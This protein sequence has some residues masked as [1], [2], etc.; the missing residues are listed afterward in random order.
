MKLISARYLAFAV[1]TY[2]I[3]ASCKNENKSKLFSLMSPDQTG[4]RFTNTLLSTEEFNI[5]SYRNFYNGAGVAISDFNN[6]DLPEIYLISNM[7]TNKL[8]QNKGN[9]TF[10]DITASAGVGG[11]K[12][13]S[14]GVVVADVNG[15][16]YLD[17]Y[18]CNAGYLPDKSDQENELFINNGDLTFTEM[19]AEYGLNDNGFTTHAAFFDYDLDGDLDVYVLNNSF[20]PVN[21]LNYSN[22][23]EL[24]SKDWPVRDFLKGGGDK[25][26]RNDNGRFTD[27]TREA[28]IYSSLIGFGL[29]VTV[30]D[31]NGD[32]LPDIYISNDFFERDYLYIN[33]GDG[34]FSEELEDRMGHI[35]LASMGADMA[36]INNDG[37]PEIFVSE[38]L[39]DEEY[40]LRTEVLFESYPNY[41][42]KL[43][44][45]FYHQ[46]MHNTLQLNNGDHTFSEIA[47]YAGVAAS[48]WSWGALLFDADNDGYRDI[49]ICNGTLQD[50]TN[51]DFI[52]FFADEVVQKMALKGEKDEIEYVMNRM[53]SNM[54]YNRFFH[55]NKD[56]TFSECGI[57]SGFDTKSFSNGAAYGDLDN[58]GDLDLI[59]NNLNQ[60]TFILRNNSNTK[61]ENHYVSVKLDGYEQ[62]KFAVGSLVLVYSDSLIFNNYLIPS[63]GFQSSVD[64]KMVFGLGSVSVI[65]SLVVIWP[66]KKRSQLSKPSIDTTYIFRY[67]EASNPNFP[68]PYEIDSIS[69]YFTEIKMNFESH[70][71]DEYVDFLSER[72]II[73]MLSREGQT[74]AVADVNGDDLVDIFLGGASGQSAQLYIQTVNGFVKKSLDIF[75]H[76]R[77]FEDTAVKFFDADN[78]GDLDLYVGS[79]GNHQPQNSGIFRDR[80]YLNDGEGNFHRN[81][82]PLPD[83]NYN[84]SVICPFD[85]DGDADIDLF[86]G[87]RSVPMNYGIPPKSYIFENLGN[88]TFKDATAY[89]APF[90]QNLGMVTDAKLVDLTDNGE[91][92]LVIVGEWMSPIILKKNRNK[93]E[94][95]P[96]NLSEYYGWWNVIS[97]D[98]IDGDGDQDLI[99]GN[100]GDNFYFTGSAEMPAKLWL[101]D[102][103]NNGTIEKI[104]TRRINDKDMTLSL[105]RELS[106]QIS[107]PMLHNMSYKD[108]SDKSIQEL[109]PERLL[110]KA[111]IQLGTW[112]KSCVAIN[113]G[114]G[115]FILK[116]F[117]AEVQFSS[118]NAILVSDVNDDGKNDLI[119]GGNDSGFMPQ[120]SKHDASYGHVLI[121][122]GIGN[123]RYIPSRESGFFVKGDIREF[124]NFPYKGENHFLV[125][126]NNQAPRMFKKLVQ[127]N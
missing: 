76:D 64:Y 50:V 122:D 115:Y 96:T 95:L 74:G 13:W 93:Y 123:Y 59:I 10:E 113:E 21:T 26:Y 89:Y 17:I 62:N 69:H 104:I 27:V 63:R 108:F 78:D 85:I 44:R 23:R 71:E 31:V 43:Q 47:W 2:S 52:Y 120:Y 25:L 53:P 73:K 9:L 57:E 92:E 29:G 98:D 40:R 5:F 30:G 39:P 77:H 42:M 114:N 94:I 80:L 6:D 35:S 117:P 38:M 7:E 33:R 49:Y 103:D 58:D 109:F 45:G 16:G 12:A 83:N 106:D 97:T 19:A 60:E 34:T 126:I 55:N 37:F 67:P 8:Y 118:V 91:N 107:L 101:W 3:L 100:R 54:Q 81:E 51:Q 125:L 32:Q 68:N 75:M 66:D 105:K 86:V 127:T 56:L 88:G 124:I 22:Q 82:T 48:D 111:K 70:Q 84:T 41:N 112:F 15:D 4:I 87:S 90:L 99:L 11:T 116:A 121:N 65:D 24:D 72:L 46:Y 36:D 110:E 61:L 119:M 28:G 79:G 20:M 18:V 102:F 14:T 1:L